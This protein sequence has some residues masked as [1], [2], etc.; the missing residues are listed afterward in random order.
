MITGFL[1]SGE[2]PDDAILRETKEELGLKGHA[3][4]FIGHFALPKFNQ[5]IIAFAIEA[6]GELKLNEEISEVKIISR[7]ALAEYDFGDFALTRAIVAS[8]LRD[9]R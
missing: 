7:D 4:Q 9:R 6:D 2:L 5:L 8:H 3:C 1:E